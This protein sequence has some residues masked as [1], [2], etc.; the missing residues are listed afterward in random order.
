MFVRPVLK[1]FMQFI[2]RFYSVDRAFSFADLSREVCELRQDPVVFVA[3]N[4]IAK[5][6]THILSFVCFMRLLNVHFIS[7]LCTCY[8]DLDVT[9][10]TLRVSLGMPFPLPL[11]HDACFPAKFKEIIRT[12]LSLQFSKNPLIL[13]YS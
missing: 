3:P 2:H 9:S 1:S 5:V 12:E 7:R 8:Q 4:A 6:L 13:S 11:L 10:A